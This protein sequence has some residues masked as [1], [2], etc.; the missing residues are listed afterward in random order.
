M[1]DMPISIP[2]NPDARVYGLALFLALMSGLLFGMVP[3]RQVFSTD[4]YQIVKAGSTVSMSNDHP[5]FDQTVRKVF[6]QTV[7]HVT[8]NS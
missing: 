2:V 7:S 1:P 3:V 5:I 6:A 8:G 4:P